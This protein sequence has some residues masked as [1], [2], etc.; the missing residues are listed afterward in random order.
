M[1]GLPQHPSIVLTGLVTGADH[2]DY[3]FG[4]K[5]PGAGDRRQTG[6]HRS[7]FVHPVVRFL[8]DDRAARP[9]DGR[10]HSATMLQSF[11]GGVDDGVDPLSRQVTL[12]HLQH[13]GI[14][15]MVG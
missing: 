14:V 8:L 12:N 1:N 11:V 9:D 6:T 5:R 2:M 4:R 3:I 7:V 13:P 10:R 15:T